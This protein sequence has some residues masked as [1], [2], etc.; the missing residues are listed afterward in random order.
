MRRLVTI[1]FVGRLWLVKPVNV[2]KRELPVK[3]GKNANLQAETQ[4]LASRRI[5]NDYEL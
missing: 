4:P 5:T 2:R 1:L 3:T